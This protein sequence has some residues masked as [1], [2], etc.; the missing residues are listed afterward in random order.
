MISSTKN[1]SDCIANIHCP[2]I[3]WYIR[4]KLCSKTIFLR[5]QT[6]NSL[7][8]IDDYNRYYFTWPVIFL[9]VL[10]FIEGH[11]SFPSLEM[12]AIPCGLS[13][14]C[15]T[16]WMGFSWNLLNLYLSPGLYILVPSTVST[17]YM[18]TLKTN[19]V[20]QFYLCMIILF[21]FLFTPPT[22]C[23]PI[24]RPVDYLIIYLSRRG[25]R[26]LWYWHSFRLKGTYVI[27]CLGGFDTICQFYPYLTSFTEA[28]CTILILGSLYLNLMLSL[29]LL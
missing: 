14:F 23:D 4:I 7:F 27:R 3:R 29:Y 9:G 8:K 11:R 2:H 28:S 1:I 17:S 24:I 10:Q 13:G 26:H 21:P 19:R 12:G 25:V 22:D 18:H 5:T 16:Y 6:L 15:I 20:D